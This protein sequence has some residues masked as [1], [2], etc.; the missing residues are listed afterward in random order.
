MVREAGY[1]AGE[2]LWGA[3]HCLSSDAR[4]SIGAAPS[5]DSSLLCFLRMWSAEAFVANAFRHDL[6]NL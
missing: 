2:V 6:G 3:V 4:A 5:S 1:V